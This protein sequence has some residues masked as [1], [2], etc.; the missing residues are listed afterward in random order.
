[1]SEFFLAPVP[2]TVLNTQGEVGLGKFSGAIADIDWSGLAAPYQRSTLW[3]AGHHKHWQYLALATADVFCGIAIVDVG[4]TNTAFAYAF[5]RKEKKLIASFSQDGL[6]GLTASI[7]SRPMLGAASHFHF[8]RNRIDFTGASASDSARLNLVC[9]DF[10]IHAQLHEQQAAPAL[11]AIGTVVGGTV[12]ATVKSAGMPMTGEVQVAGRRYS[13]DGGVASTDHSNGFLARETDWRWAS[14]HGLDVGFNLQ[15]GY[16]GNNENALWLDG[17]LISL[18]TARFDFDPANP[19]AS[20][21]ITTD[22]GLLDVVFQP[23]GCRRE[24]KNLLIAA[25]RYVQPVGTFSGWVKAHP[26]AE[27]SAINNLVGVTEDHFS[28]W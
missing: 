18:S 24:D 12:H 4:W 7:N 19:L 15:S 10:S 2:Q 23:E 3:R 26:G 25:S 13:L 8:L 14:A 1:M 5:D 22:D 6:P 20:W 28:R 21:H 17:K 11:T 27:P 9:G 16:F